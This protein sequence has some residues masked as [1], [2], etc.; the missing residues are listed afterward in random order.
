MARTIGGNPLRNA[1]IRQGNPLPR[2]REVP[3]IWVD[4]AKLTPKPAVVGKDRPY[5]EED[6]RRL[7]API[8]ITNFG[9]KS[10]AG[11]TTNR[12]VNLGKRQQGDRYGYAGDWADLDR[13]V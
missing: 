3:M 7:L 8:N 2:K 4:P 1:A 10:H 5:T 13:I 12:D 9:G 6:R 11:S